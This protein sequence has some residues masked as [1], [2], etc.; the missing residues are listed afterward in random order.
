MAVSSGGDTP[1]LGRG[2]LQRPRSSSESSPIDRQR[3]RSLVG[4]LTSSYKF[5]EGGLVK[6]VRSPQGTR[7]L[8]IR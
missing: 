8:Y 7:A 2:A 6:K 1:P 5:K 4:S 3:A